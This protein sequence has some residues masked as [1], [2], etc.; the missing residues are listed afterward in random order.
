MINRKISPII[1]PLTK[2][3]LPTI[4]VRNSVANDIKYHYINCTNEFVRI[5]VHFYAGKAYQNHFLVSTFTNALL[6]E[7]TKFHSS[8]EI[9][10]NLDYYGAWL[11]TSSSIEKA[12]LTLYSL[13]KFLP[14]TLPIL[15]EVM[16][17]PSFPENEFETLKKQRI[18]SYLLSLE[19]VEELSDRQFNK[20][21]YGNQSKYSAVAELEDYE[22][23]R[24]DW[25]KDFFEKYY[26]SSPCDVFV[27]G[28]LTSDEQ[29]QIEEMFKLY[30]SS[31]ETLQ[32]S[33]LYQFSPQQAKEV[34]IEKK[35]SVQSA[36]NIGKILFSRKHPDFHKFSLLNTVL[37]GY[38]GSRLMSNI[39]EEK[40][41]TYGINSFIYTHAEIGHFQIGTQ[42]ANEYVKP[43]LKEI[44]FEIQRLCNDLIPDDELS[45]VKN[46]MTG[47]LARTLD[48]DLSKTNLYISLN[49]Y[50]LDIK[51]YVSDRLDAINNTTSE[52]LR[53]LAQ[54][55]L[56]KER[57]HQ[58][59]VGKNI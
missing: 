20:E 53:T 40:G 45:I 52:E 14:H 15:N 4:E 49:N 39:R 1:S 55:Y 30:Q 11:K 8:R 41:Y 56:G 46:Y 17:Y 50:G 3:N 16:K 6:R 57:L 48:G 5:D 9:A 28:N 21:L 59:V 19:K 38:F 58:V 47:S 23:I 24:I 54:N 29:K 51:E 13:K 2:F 12:S 43:V 37:G 26:T 44:Q 42:T 31:S 27:M 22:K 36:I 33:P 32:D 34:F 35:D 7:G 25:I 10:E 18:Q